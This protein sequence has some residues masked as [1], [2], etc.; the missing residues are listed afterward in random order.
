VCIPRQTTTKQL[1]DVGQRFFQQ[2]PD[3]RNREAGMLL[4]L[5]FRFEWPCR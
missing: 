5:A 4:G 3:Y 1:V 2:H